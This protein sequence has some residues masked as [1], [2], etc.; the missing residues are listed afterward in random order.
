M[1]F[2]GY[3]MAFAACHQDTFRLRRRNSSL[4]NLNQIFAQDETSDKPKENRIVKFHDEAPERG[5]SA[6]KSKSKGK[7]RSLVRTSTSILK[8]TSAS[9]I[10]L[11]PE[12]KLVKDEVTAGGKHEDEAKNGEHSKKKEKKKKRGVKMDL[13]KVGGS[14]KS[15][16][17]LSSQ[18]GAI[19]SPGSAS[20]DKLQSLSSMVPVNINFPLNLSTEES[21]YESDLTRKTSSKVR[22]GA[23]Y[24]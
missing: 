19:S 8:D 7:S 4:E 20:E 21:G 9:A 2:M 10:C 16:E 14:K 17:S 6:K 12:S 5:R 18:Q 3:N 24:H 23:N 15:S 13:E 22:S 1:T 11:V